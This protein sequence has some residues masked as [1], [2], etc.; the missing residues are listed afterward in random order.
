MKRWSVKTSAC[1]PAPE[2]KNT[3]FF[4]TK[5][6]IAKMTESTTTWSCLAEAWS[7]QTGVYSHAIVIPALLSRLIPDGELE[8]TLQ[9]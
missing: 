5:S 8:P 4:Q 3:E 2:A 7:Q 9:E 1:F 6:Q